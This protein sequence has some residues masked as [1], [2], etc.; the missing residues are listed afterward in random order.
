MTSINTRIQMKILARVLSIPFAASLLLQCCQSKTVT[1]DFNVTWVTANPDGLYPRKVVGINGQWL[2]PVIEVDKGDRIVANVYNGLGDKDT[3]NQMDGLSMVTQCPIPL[4]ASFTYN[5]TVNQNS[6]HA[7][8]T[9]R[10]SS[11]RDLTYQ[12]PF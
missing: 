7:L 3:T 8:Q 9:I 11:V 5:F 4:G 10:K 6:Y 1:Y 12:R 2:L